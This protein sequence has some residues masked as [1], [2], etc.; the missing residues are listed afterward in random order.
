MVVNSIQFK[1][2]LQGGLSNLV[3]QS[4]EMVVNERVHELP[5]N[6][7]RAKKIETNLQ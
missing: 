1:R 6:F 2:H 4:S 7:S 5:S 3:C